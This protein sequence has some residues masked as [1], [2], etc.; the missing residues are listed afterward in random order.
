LAG[1]FDIVDDASDDDDRPTPADPADDEID[2]ARVRR[3]A[4]ERRALHRARLWQLGLAVT[5]ACGA[6]TAAIRA[7]DAW[8]AG[9]WRGWALA[10]IAVGLLAAARRLASRSNAVARRIAASRQAE[11]AAPATF[12]TL[13]DGSQRARALREMVDGP[14]SPRYPGERAG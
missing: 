8:R 4:V 13:G 2:L 6:V 5:L 11:P 7:A 9:G 10:A 1:S 14:P 3:V 12:D